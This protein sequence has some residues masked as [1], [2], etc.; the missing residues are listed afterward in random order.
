MQRKLFVQNIPPRASEEELRQLFEEL[1][2]VK[3]AKIPTD[4]RSGKK[5]GFGFVEMA[6]AK[7]AIEAIKSINQKK[8][9]GRKLKVAF[10]EDRNR[11]RSLAYS[12]LF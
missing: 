6:T 12:Y 7:A 5:R 8:L 4:R 11:R 2:E 3:S 1:G 10:S 9:H